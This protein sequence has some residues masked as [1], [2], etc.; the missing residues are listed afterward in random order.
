MWAFPVTVVIGHTYA[1]LRYLTTLEKMPSVFVPTFYVPMIY[2]IAVS[3][4]ISIHNKKDFILFEM[5]NNLIERV[6][7]ILKAFPERI[8]I[9]KW[10]K[11]GSVEYPFT[12]DELVKAQIEHPGEVKEA[13]FE[14]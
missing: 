5:Q 3:Y 2:V 10:M 4:I 12:N 11:D 14:M 9:S 13:I 7:S 8:V 1:L 6:Y